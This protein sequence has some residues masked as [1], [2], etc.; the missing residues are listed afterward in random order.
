MTLSFSSQ[1]IYSLSRGS[2]LMPFAIA[3]FNFN[4][5]VQKC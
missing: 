5:L 4:L 1:V 2:L 3:E